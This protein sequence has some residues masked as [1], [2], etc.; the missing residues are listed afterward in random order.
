M[1]VTT[2][3]LYSHGSRQP[4]LLAR[5][6]G[7]EWEIDRDHWLA[8]RPG[9]QIT[10]PQRMREVIVAQEAATEPGPSD[11]E[12]AAAIVEAINNPGEPVAVDRIGQYLED[13]SVEAHADV[14]Q[15]CDVHGYA[16]MWQWK[17]AGGCPTCEAQTEELNVLEQ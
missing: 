10:V 9:V 8:K 15:G 4:E 7:D 3:Q 14:E 17:L 12:V 13:L 16:P 11:H 5:N 1:I 2:A 6:P